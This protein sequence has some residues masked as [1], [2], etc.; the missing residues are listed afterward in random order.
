MAFSIKNDEADRLARQLAA[1]TGES[2]TETVVRSLSERLG[3][4]RV[5]KH[6][7]AGSELARLGAELRKLP[8]LDTRSDEDLLGYDENGLPN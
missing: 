6:R 5:S 4:Q 8:V 1:L 7:K 2:L 3:R